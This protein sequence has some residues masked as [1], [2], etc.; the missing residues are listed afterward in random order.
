MKEIDLARAST[1]IGAAHV[2][3]PII[4][5]DTE[6][7]PLIFLEIMDASGLSCDLCPLYVRPN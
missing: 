4:S 2:L 6:A 1:T 5:R 3:A 7:L